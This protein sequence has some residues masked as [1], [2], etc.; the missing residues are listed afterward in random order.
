MTG[1]LFPL[2]LRLLLFLSLSL[3]LSLS[4]SSPS[5]CPL[6]CHPF[7]AL[8]FFCRFLAICRF[9]PGESLARY[10]QSWRYALLC[11]AGLDWEGRG[12]AAWLGANQS[13]IVLRSESHIAT[14]SRTESVM[15]RVISWSRIRCQKLSMSFIGGSCLEWGCWKP[16]ESGLCIT[17]F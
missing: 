6:F 17:H 7:L 13:E 11:W 10:S 2:W 8:L 5:C 9:S 4:R 1:H 15:M 14:D 16:S 3:S 12:V